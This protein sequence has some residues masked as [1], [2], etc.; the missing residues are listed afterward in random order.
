MND[1]LILFLVLLFQG[2]TVGV[3]LLWIIVGLNPK[4]WKK[5]LN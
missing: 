4:D 3:L 2:I 1:V 5:K